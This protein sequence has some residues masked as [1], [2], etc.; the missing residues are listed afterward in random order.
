M[1]FLPFLLEPVHLL[2]CAIYLSA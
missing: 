2:V 1:R